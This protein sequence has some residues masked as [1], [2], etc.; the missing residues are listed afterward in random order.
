MS[1]FTFLQ[2]EW[3]VVFEAASKA[4]LEV[5]ADPLMACLYTRCPFL[6]TL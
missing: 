1:Q 5:Y 6:G 4:E 2:H 3:A